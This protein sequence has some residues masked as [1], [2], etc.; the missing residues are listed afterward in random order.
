MKYYI[1]WFRDFGISVYPVDKFRKGFDLVF[2]CVT[3]SVDYGEQNTAE[4]T[5]T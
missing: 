3:I 2:I 1:K 5:Q 4:N